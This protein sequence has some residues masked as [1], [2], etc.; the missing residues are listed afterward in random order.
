MSDFEKKV[1]LS[2]K[3]SKKILGGIFDKKKLKTGLVF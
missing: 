3:I 1:N 2:E